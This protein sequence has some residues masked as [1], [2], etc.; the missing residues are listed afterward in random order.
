SFLK[1]ILPIILAIIFYIS[2]FKYSFLNIF[3]FLRLNPL[4]ITSI[5]FY[6][7]NKFISLTIYFSVLNI[8]TLFFPSLFY[9][10]ITF[11]IFSFL[12]FLYLFIFIIYSFLLYLDLYYF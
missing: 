9:V 8:P 3:V 11:I 5:I 6:T 12:F 10:I 7:V 4:L 2:I 1:L